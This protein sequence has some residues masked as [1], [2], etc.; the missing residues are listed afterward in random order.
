LILALAP[1]LVPGVWPTVEPWIKA[2]LERTQTRTHLPLDILIGILKGECVLWTA[3]RDGNVEAALVSEV[4]TYPRL[5]RCHI[6]ALGGTGLRR[7]YG[8]MERQLEEYARAQGC[9]EW[10]CMG[11]EGWERWCGMRRAGAFFTKDL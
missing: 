1:H 2:A 4:Q 5:K 3:W 6:V 10:S 9:T 8:A 7:W 11:R